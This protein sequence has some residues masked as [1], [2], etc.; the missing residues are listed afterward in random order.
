MSKKYYV[1]N[2]DTGVGRVMRST[3]HLTQNFIVNEVKS[4]KS[5]IVLYSQSLLNDIQK[6]RDRFGKTK[7]N[8]ALRT[9]SQNSTLDTSSHVKGCAFDIRQYKGVAIDVMNRY[10]KKIRSYKGGTGLYYK[11]KF[12]HVDNDKVKGERE[13]KGKGD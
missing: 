3:E 4:Y 8:S 2:I 7:I 5:E 10:W 12:F 6:M 13:W 11:K 1:V 9:L